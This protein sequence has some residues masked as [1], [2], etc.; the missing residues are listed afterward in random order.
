MR[1]TWTIVGLFTIVTGTAPAQYLR[2]VNVSQAEWGDPWSA[3]YGTEYSYPSAPTFNYFSARALGFIRLQVLWERLQPV[4]GGPLD[5][6]NL[7]NLQQ[8]VAYAKASGALVSIVPHNQARYAP[9]ESFVS[10]P[11]IIDNPC[12]GSPVLVTAA[13]LANFWVAMSNAFKDEP[14]VM[15]Y[16]LMNEPHDMGTDANGDPVNWGQIAQT[17]VTAIRANGDNKTIMIPGD[18]WSNATYWTTYNG[19]APFITDPANN[20]YYEAHE[21]FDSD[22]SGT[23]AET[24]DQ[25]LA[26]NPGLADVGVSR[27]LPFALWCETYKAPC[28]LGEYGIPNNDPRWLT[29]LDNFL[30]ELD[31]AS[32]PGTYWAAGEL[33]ATVPTCSCSLLSVQPANNFTTDAE[34]LPTLLAH[35]PPNSF[36]TA[37]AAASYGWASAPGELTAGYGSGLAAGTGQATELPLPTELKGAQVQLTDSS[38]NVTF[39][40][41]LYVSPQQINYQVPA[42]MAAGLV[43]AAVLNGTTTVSTGVLEVQP[44]APTIFTANSTGQ[45]VPAAQIQRVHPDGTYD[46]ESVAT[47]DSGTGFVPA[48]IAF[49]G[50]NLY[51]LLYGTGFDHASG[52]SGTTVNIGTT[53]ASVVFSGPQS[54]FAGLDQI[55]AQLPGSLAGA[56]QVTVTVT[57]DGM[58][59]NPVTIA[60]Q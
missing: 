12:P 37:S 29:V 15:A 31:V 39:A 44:I 50:D 59:A 49:N 4:L 53:D 19:S 36:R 56:G 60:F 35:L 20:Y 41:L 13:D 6:T 22:Y 25:E 1:I 42:G 5:P 33:W 30:R 21:Y 14:A 32:M 8:D 16:D 23:Y 7:A 45:G 26:A 28:Y 34:Q 46:Y 27:L 9:N 52:T 17:V 43:T 3:T 55:D 48:P 54:Q 51:L 38:G 58:T 24:Y 47:Y 18:G 10:N 57:V 11:C 2:G 40:P